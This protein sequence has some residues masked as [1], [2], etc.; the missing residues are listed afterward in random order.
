MPCW[1]PKI[2]R[3][4][5]SCLDASSTLNPHKC[6]AKL[7][8]ACDNGYQHVYGHPSRSSHVAHARHIARAQTTSRIGGSFYFIPASNHQTRQ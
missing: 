2:L 8:A 1:T 7:A 4:L 6:L 5:S 3:P